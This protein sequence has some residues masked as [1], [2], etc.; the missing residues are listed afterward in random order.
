MKP[1]IGP[2]SIDTA[3]ELVF[4]FLSE[5]VSVLVIDLARL[6][7]AK[8]RQTVLKDDLQLAGAHTT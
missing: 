6:T 7:W 1:S 3:L 8:L 2:L 4:P 5:Q